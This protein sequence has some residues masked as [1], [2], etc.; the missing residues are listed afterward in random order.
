MLCLSRTQGLMAKKV[1]GYDDDKKFE[2]FY[3]LSIGV[4]DNVS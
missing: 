2:R 4:R 3:C 1:K